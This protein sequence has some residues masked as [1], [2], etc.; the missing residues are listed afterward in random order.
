MFAICFFNSCE[1]EWVQFFLD[2]KLKFQTQFPPLSNEKVCLFMK[3]NIL[4][5]DISEESSIFH[6]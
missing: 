2:L 5:I 3:T 6:K 4:Q 1:A